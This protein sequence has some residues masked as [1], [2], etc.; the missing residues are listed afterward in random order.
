[1]DVEAVTTAFGHEDG[2]GRFRE[3]CEFRTVYASAYSRLRS[4]STGERKT[5]C[6][7]SFGQAST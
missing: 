5:G 1:M 4:L 6:G 3:K 2:T 7:T